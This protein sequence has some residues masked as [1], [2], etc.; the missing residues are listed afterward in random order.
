MTWVT[1]RQ[2]RIEAAVVVTVLLLIVT[3]L[4]V[5]GPRLTATY[6]QTGMAAYA[7][8]GDGTCS[9]SIVLNS[10]WEAKYEFSLSIIELTAASYIPLLFFFPLLFG[11][12]IGAPLV[13]REIEQGTH[14][15]AWTQSITRRHWL[16]VK[17][18]LIAG[19]IALP[20]LVTSVLFSWWREPITATVGPWGLWFVVGPQNVGSGYGYDRWGFDLQG[21]VPYAYTLFAFMLGV[22]T[23]AIVRRAVPAMAITLVVFVLVRVLIAVLLRPYYLA[24]VSTTWAY[25]PKTPPPVVQTSWLLNADTIDAQG[26]EVSSAALSQACPD[27][28]GGKQDLFAC[29]RAHGF[30]SRAWYQP[31]DRFWLFQGIESAL[32]LMLTGGLLLL[33]LWW[34]RHKVA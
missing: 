29:G 13:A 2:H 1:W 8:G 7:H 19:G 25:A 12:F 20:F 33:T 23:G 32:F 17:I 21:V 28:K 31:A 6:Q 15:L 27:Q 5:T 10:C 18:G 22:A 9:I 30:R 34:N 3:V 4:V 16:L 24:P 11:M 14:R 26:N